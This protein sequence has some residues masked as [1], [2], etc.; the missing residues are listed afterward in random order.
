MAMTMRN[1]VHGEF[2]FG[3]SQGSI[4][5]PLLFNTF[6]CDFF[7]FT[8]GTDIANYADDNTPY[9]SE[10]TTCKFIE[11]LQECFGDMFT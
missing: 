3:V 5:G 9:S 7:L 2:I 1:S 4:L 8:Y 10:S 6:L 11:C